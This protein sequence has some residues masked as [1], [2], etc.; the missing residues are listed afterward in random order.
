MV[1]DLRVL[2]RWLQKR[3]DQPTAA[4]VDSRT[5]QSTPESGAR[6]GYDG[7][8]HKNGSKVHLATTYEMVEAACV[9]QGDTGDQP[10]A[11]AAA[12]W[13][14][15]EMITVPAAN[16]GF[17][18]WPRRWVVERSCAW[19]ARFRRLSRDSD[20]LAETVASLHVVAFA[21]LMVHR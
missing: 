18:L 9:D 19:A 15:L 16:R 13:S 14:A 17:V 10:T 4:I 20:R 8:K 1:H 21:C 11:D 12:H 7:A 2:L 5:S 6:A 3:A